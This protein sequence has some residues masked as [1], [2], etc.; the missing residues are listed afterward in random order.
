MAM[1]VVRPAAE[2]RRRSHAARLPIRTGS[3]VCK[4]GGGGKK[5]TSIAVARR[6]VVRVRRW[7]PLTEVVDE[8]TRKIGVRI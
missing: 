8:R 6:R 7:Q 3:S 5:K 1:M 2:T 4:A